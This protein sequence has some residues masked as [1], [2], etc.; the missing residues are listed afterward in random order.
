MNLVKPT[1]QHYEQI[2]AYREVFLERGETPYG[3]SSLQKFTDYHKWLDN[4][5]SQEI[6][7][8]L[9]PHK[10]PVT[11][12]LSIENGELIGL[13]NIRHVLTPELLMNGGHIGYSIHPNRRRK[14]YA[15]EQLRLSLL[16]AQKLGL[17]Q[18]LVT[19][20]KSNIASAKTIEKVGGILENEIK[21]LK[22]KES[23]LRYW[24]KI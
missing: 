21:P 17:E 12:F 4:V 22:S 6:E 10:V 8:L 9:P 3:G 23:V 2:M 19:C 20:D 18:I 16:E 15:A 14:G 5:I 13:I 7:E 24:I 1:I 11:Q